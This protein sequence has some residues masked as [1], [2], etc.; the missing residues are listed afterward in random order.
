MLPFEMEYI[1]SKTHVEAKEIQHTPV[2][3]A[4]GIT[5][6]IGFITSAKPCPFLRDN[7]QCGIHEIRPLDCRSFPL[8]PEFN[9]DESLGFRVDK[10]C[11]SLHTFS[12]PYR[13]LLKNIWMGL[14]SKL[15]MN[16]RVLYN[17]L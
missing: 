13:D 9:T 2:E 6:D 10:D 1:F 16:Y 17:K 11:P 8:I 12:N 4:P 14:L 7:H 3:L 15:P 5:I